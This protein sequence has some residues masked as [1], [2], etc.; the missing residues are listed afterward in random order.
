MMQIKKERLQRLIGRGVVTEAELARIIRES[1]NT[2]NYPE[3]ILIESGVPRY[4]VLLS[5]AGYHDCPFVEYDEGVI[6]SRSL[7][8]KVDMEE[9]KGLL[10][11]PLSVSEESAEV[12]AYLPHDAAVV[13]QIRQMLHVGQITFRVALPYDIIRIIEHNQDVNPIFRLRGGLLSQWCGLFA[14]RR[15]LM[16]CRRTD[17]AKGRTGLAFIRTG[18]L[19]IA[20]ALLL[21]R[22][23]GTGYLSVIELLLFGSGVVMTVDGLL[24]YLPVRRRGERRYSAGQQSRCRARQC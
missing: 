19:F 4:E 22:V 14:D 16:A 21:L 2:G 8:E 18:V 5:L 7:I 24:W 11:V 17:L 12:I 15:S 3:E 6:L 20:I 23:F 13:E 10:W 1:E 9:L